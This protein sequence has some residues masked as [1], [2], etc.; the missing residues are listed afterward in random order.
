MLGLHRAASSANQRHLDSLAEFTHVAWPPVPPHHCLGL[1]TPGAG[2][3]SMTGHGLA[4]EEALEQTYVLSPFTQRWNRQRWGRDSVVEILAEGPLPHSPIEIRVGRRQDTNIDDSRLR[5][6]NRPDFLAVKEA[7]Q[8]HLKGRIEVTDLVKEK[9]PVI[10]SYCQTL[11]CSICTCVGAFHRTEK[12]GF[13]KV[14]RNRGD[15][16]GHECAATIGEAME[17][18]SSDF[19]TDSGLPHKKDRQMGRTHLAQLASH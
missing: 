13:K 11:P 8:F 10:R 4:F 19:F 7:E 14:G 17:G 9:R 1:A 6:A 12:F 2:R 18:S 15:I 16:D 3:N 5:G